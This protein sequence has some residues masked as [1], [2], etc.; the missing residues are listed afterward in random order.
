[1]VKLKAF[2]DRVFFAIWLVTTRI[3]ICFIGGSLANLPLKI[4]LKGGSPHLKKSPRNTASCETS[5][6]SVSA[7]SCGRTSRTGFSTAKELTTSNI[8]TWW[9]MF[10]AKD[11]ELQQE[12][13]RLLVNKSSESFLHE[14][15]TELGAHALAGRTC[16]S[17]LVLEVK[18]QC[19]MFENE[20]HLCKNFSPEMKIDT[21]ST[22]IYTPGHQVARTLFSHHLF[23]LVFFMSGTAQ[24]RGDHHQDAGNVPWQN[25]H[26]EKSWLLFHINMFWPGANT[27]QTS[28]RK[29]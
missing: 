6:L 10:S 7:I 28:N 14:T 8:S 5:G 22:S 25:G 17:E 1:M 11:K 12:V 19:P 13:F 24:Q 21:C 27:H 9:K 4:T 29:T 15:L 2:H 23:S 26:I 3:L 20:F 18:I 16:P